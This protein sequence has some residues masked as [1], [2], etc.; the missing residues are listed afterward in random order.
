LLGQKVRFDGGHKKDRYITDTLGKYFQFVPV[1]PEL[2]VGM[3]VPREAVRLE[4]RLDSPSMIGVKSGTD[5]TGKMT[6]FSEQ[7]TAR[8]DIADLSGY[9]LKKNSP[10]CGMTRVKVYNK[11]GV[12]QPSGVGLFA[13]VLLRHNP[14]LPV[15]EEGRLNDPDIREN[16]LVRVFAYYRFQQ[17]CSD[18]FS[19]ARLVDF[20]TR[21]KYLVMAHSVKHYKLLGRLV[22]EVKRH[23]PAAIRDQYGKLLMEGLVVKSTVAKN[24]NVL[25]HIMGYLKRQLGSDEKKD[26]LEVIEDYHHHLVPLIVPIALIR[27]YIRKYEIDYIANQIYL[28]PHPKEL[29]LRNHV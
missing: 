23:R 26:I 29:M 12:A 7:R 19:A 16:F 21:H 4:G 13:A 2:E 15:E 11:S 5:W 3:G 25:Q 18:R 6:R 10:S 28:N 17:F 14:L 24:V 1:C 9:I 27:H 20:H 22:A 8:S